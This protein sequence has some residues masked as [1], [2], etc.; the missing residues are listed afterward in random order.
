VHEATLMRALMRKIESVAR[1]AGAERVTGI[2]VRLGALSH[3]SPEHFLEHF[4]VSSRGTLAAGA[5]CRIE[6][7]DDPAEPGA[8]DI[9][10]LSVDVEEP[11]AGEAGGAA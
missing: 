7:S 6:T 8:Q 11:A 5:S 2:A 3:M 1:D 10:L 4:E 9:L